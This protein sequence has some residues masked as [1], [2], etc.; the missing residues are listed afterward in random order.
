[1]NKKPSIENLEKELSWEEAVGR[2][3]EQ[4]PDYFLRHPELLAALVLPHP[5]AGRA[6]SLVER[7]VRV[8][9]DRNEQ[10]THQLQELIAFAR[11]NDQLGERVQRFALAMIDS[12][13]LDEVLD[14][15]QDMLRQEFN[16]DG[17]AVRLTGNPRP[18]CPRQEF[19]ATVRRRARGR[20]ARSAVRPTGGEHPLYGRDRSHAS[21]IARCAGARQPRPAA[22]PRRHGHRLP[23]TPR[24]TPHGRRRPAPGY[25]GRK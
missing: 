19:V 12:D 13:S 14:T 11:D 23:R 16:L 17:V 7:Q 6:V 20:Y 4:T 22:L 25:C 15:A 24:R 8:L 1:M 18:S 3:L 2:Y 21:R 10:S 5:E 9:R